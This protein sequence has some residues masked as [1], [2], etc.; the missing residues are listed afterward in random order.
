MHLRALHTAGQLDISSQEQLQGE[1][2]VFRL[3]LRPGRSYT[4]RTTGAT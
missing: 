3:S 1:E 2:E 4:S